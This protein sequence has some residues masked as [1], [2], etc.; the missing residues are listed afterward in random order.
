A[1]LSATDTLLRQYAW[2]TD[3]SGTMTGAGGVGGLLWMRPAGGPAHFAAYDGN[4]NVTGLV[5][6]SDGT[7]SARYEYDPFGNIIRMTGTGTI[8]RDN[9]FRFSTKRTNDDTD[10]V[11]YEYRAY[12]PDLGR[13]QNRDPI[14]EEGGIHLY[15]FVGNSPLSAIDPL[16]LAS[17]GSAT[18][19]Q[20]PTL[21]LTPEQIATAQA[22]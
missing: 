5:D 22:A 10:F 20:Y 7:L 19:I 21:L 16:G 15:S 2:G 14:E 17:S 13:W 9:P 12:S 3:L 8:A 18:L 4:G 11:L 6:G 1:E